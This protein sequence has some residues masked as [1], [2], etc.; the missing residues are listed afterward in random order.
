[1]NRGSEWRAKSYWLEIYEWGLGFVCEVM[2]RI[3]AA[4]CGPDRRLIAE[5][6]S[7]QAVAARIAGSA[8]VPMGVP[9]SVAPGVAALITLI[10]T[11][12]AGESFCARPD[13]DIVE[14]IDRE[15]EK[16]HLKKS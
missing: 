14:A 12:S 11:R 16:E 15:I 3:C 5:C 2:G 1:M 10:L 13:R 8:L 7:P 9:G 6:D 4:V